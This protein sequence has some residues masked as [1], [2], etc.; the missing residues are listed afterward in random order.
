MNYIAIDIGGTAIKAGIVSSEGVIL[1][2]T[3]MPTPK[4]SFEDMIHELSHIVEWAQSVT[5]IHGI[6]VSQPC[7]TDAITGQAL[8]EGALIYINGTNPS[9]T[10]GDQ[11]NLPYAA[12]NDGNCAALAEV[13]IGNAKNS[14]NVALV[15]CGTGI[16]GSVIIDQ[17]IISG[18]RKFAG[19]FGFFISGF[20]ADGTPVTWSGSGSTTA[21]VNAYAKRTGQDNNQLNGKIIFERAEQG[22]ETACDCVDTFYKLFAY[23]VHNIQHVYD[24]DLILIGGAISGRPDF[25]EQIDQRQIGRASCWVRF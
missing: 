11:F 12:E 17:K 4:T 19:E 18:K 6:A 14:K 1:E 16:G 24:P 2:K 8:S 20:E 21:L 10:L 5:D 7:A 3:T 9:K 13:W 23:G 22:E 15:V 25:I